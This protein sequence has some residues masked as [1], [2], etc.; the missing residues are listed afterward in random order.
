M[1]FVKATERLKIKDP[2][3]GAIRR[4][5]QEG[6]YRI[7]SEAIAEAVILWH[8][9]PETLLRTGRPDSVRPHTPR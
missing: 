5:L 9:S 2:D 1:S 4:Q 6:S 3:V 8:M 7:A